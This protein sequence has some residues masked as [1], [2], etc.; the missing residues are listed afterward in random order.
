ML[1]CQ[2]SESKAQLSVSLSLASLSSARGEESEFR[3]EERRPSRREAPG[4]ERE[5]RAEDRTMAVSKNPTQ[6]CGEQGPV[7][8]RQDNG[9]LN[10]AST[11]QMP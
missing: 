6:E 5:Q 9:S 7:K 2:V 8:H 4:P 3:G 11:K 10:L 1:L